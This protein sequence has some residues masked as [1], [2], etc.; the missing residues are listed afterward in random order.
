MPAAWFAGVYGEHGGETA[1][2]HER[3]GDRGSDAGCAEAFN[4]VGALGIGLGVFEDVG[5]SGGERVPSRGG[6][7][8]EGVVTDHR[9]QTVDEVSEDLEGAAIRVHY[10]VGA[11]IHAQVLAEEAGGAVGDGGG[12]YGDAGGG[13]DLGEQTVAFANE[14]EL[15]A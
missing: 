5:L 11:T 7:L 12:V 4:T 8:V 10:D 2:R 14:F 13:V 9:G 1:L 3:A 6:E 15:V